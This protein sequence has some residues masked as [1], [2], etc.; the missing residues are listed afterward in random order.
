MKKIPLILIMVFSLFVYNSCK[1]ETLEVNDNFNYVTFGAASYGTGVDVGGTASVEVEV[2]SSQAASSDRTFTISVDPTS[3]AAAGSYT[4]PPSVIIPSGSQT[5]T[6]SVDLSDVDLGIGVNS[7]II[8]F[9][10]EDG[11]FVGSPTTIN[12]TQNCNETTLILDLSFDSWPEETTWQVKDALGGVVASGG[13]YGGMASASEDV[14]LCIGRD[15]TFE[16]ADS[17]GDGG[18]TYS[19]SLNGNVLVS[20]GP[21]YGAGESKAFSTE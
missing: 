3:N 20:G 9:A 21:A 6:F 10:D 7:L 4:V 16:I 2:L 11:L 15:Y 12:Y 17:F 1:E 13:N 18:A 5:G 19:L 14:V 8:T